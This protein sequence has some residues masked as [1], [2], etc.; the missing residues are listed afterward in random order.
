VPVLEVPTV[1]GH[2]SE[3]VPPLALQELAPLL[4]QAN[5][6]VCPTVTTLGVAVNDEMVAAGVALTTVTLADC[7]A[8]APPGPVQ[9]KVYT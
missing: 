8:L 4:L 7:G 6:E 5:E 3:P 9:F 1:P 2:E